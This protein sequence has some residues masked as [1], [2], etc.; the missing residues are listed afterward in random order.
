M[1]WFMHILLILVMD[2]GFR[3]PSDNMGIDDR[4]YEVKL[5]RATAQRGGWSH[6]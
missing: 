1:T 2:M 3:I 4:S 6:G 5:T